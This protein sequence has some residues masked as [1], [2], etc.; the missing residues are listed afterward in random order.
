MNEH[1]DLFDE[2]AAG[3]HPTDRTL[4][5][6]LRSWRDA[7]HDATVVPDERL[8]ARFSN[9]PPLPTPARW[10]QWMQRPAI[11]FAASFAAVLVLGAGAFALVA[12][13]SGVE[14]IA[15]TTSSSSVASLAAIDDEPGE[16]DL[17]SDLTEQMS[18]GTCVLDELTAWLTSGFSGDEAPHLTD[19]CGMPPI[20]D[21]GPEAAAFQEDLQAWS[22][23][24]VDA[25]DTVLPDLPD[26]L[27]KGHDGADGFAELE[28]ACGEPPDPRDYGL[29]LPFADFDWEN[30]DPGMFN[31]EGFDFGEFDLENFNLGDFN[32]DELIENL[33][34]GFL[35]EDFDPD[36]L[37]SHF[38]D[39][40]LEGF[41]LDL[42]SC[43]PADLPEL[44]DINSLEDLEDI[45][46]KAW[47]EEF[48][49]ESLCGIAGILDFDDFDL[50]QMFSDLETQ[51]GGLEGFEGFEGL[52]L[53]ELL[54][55]LLGDGE[56]DLDTLLDGFADQDV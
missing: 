9:E 4:A 18:Y 40:D 25:F 6:G 16:I 34:E 19:S 51:F 35:P 2:L 44:G 21:L 20:P 46:F 28:N 37:K 45:D 31:L 48:D 52:N 3:D 22:I 55:G 36:Q 11:A 38:G 49:G 41:K 24:M 14:D 54:G 27:S 43:D 29:E 39:F 7:N 56:F 42:E 26:L 10:R 15:A 1:N 32:L 30:L 5:A 8:E 50:E 23:C 12:R 13:D 47:F 33:P 17:P 53:E